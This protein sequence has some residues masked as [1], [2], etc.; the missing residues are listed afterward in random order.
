MKPLH[1]L[2]LS[3]IAGI[4]LPMAA[5]ASTVTW[6][7]PTAIT[8]ASDI[9]TTGLTD[10]AGANFG[11]TTGTTTL[12]TAA[13][14]GGSVDVE[15]K[16]L[17]SGQNATLSNNINVAAASAWGN[18]GN[19]AGNSA[20]TGN[21]GI[22]L[23][24]NIGIEP[25]V[26]TAN[27]TLS[28][29][30]IGTQY[31][32]QFF[33]DSTGNN[34]QAVSG[35]AG[36]NSIAGRFVTGTFTADATS[37]VLTVSYTTGDFAVVNALTIGVAGSVADTT[38]PEW[39]ATWPQ[40]DPLS[41]TS[42]TVRANA[43]EAGTAYYVVLP[44]GATPPSAAQ[45]KA[46]QDSSNTSV[47]TAGSLV[48]TASTEATTTVGSLS[49]G[50][51]YDV[52]FVAEDTVT[53]LQAASVKVDAS[54]LA[55]DVTA[56]TWTAT[57]P[58][59]TQ[60]TPTSITVR[61]QTNETGTAYYV[62]LADGATAPS[63]AQVQA[64]TDNT[65]T[66]AIAFGNFAL[67]A[68]TEATA[69]VTGL[70]ADTAYDVYLVAEDAVSNLQ[71]SPV[72]VDV[73]LV[74]PAFAWGTWTAVSDETAIQTPGGYTYGG[75]NFNGSDTTIG[76]VAFTGIAQNDSGVANGVTVTT[77][78]FAFQST[79]TGNSNVASAV[80]SPQT[81]ATVLDR[82]IGDDDD[83]ATIDL[84]GLTPGTD[85]T[86]QFFSST[87]DGG[88]NSTTKIT[89]VG[90][91]SPQFG[92]HGGGDTRYIVATFTANS[93]SQSFTINGAEPTF[94]AM[95]IGVE[96]TGNTFANWIGGYD[97]G[98]QTAFGDDAD[99]DGLDNGLENFL[100]T[101]PD[102][103]NAGLTAGTL[104][105][106][107]FTFTHPQNATPADDVSAP[108]Y[109]WSTDLVNWNAAGASAGGITVDL[110]AFTNTPSAGTTTVNATV[111]G[112][113]PPKLFVRLGVSQL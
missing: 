3:G 44:D 69:P 90:V 11:I 12:V 74:T 59:A 56:P 87:P 22:V 94:S 71:A 23:D 68:N 55:P 28:G 21:F 48:L 81:W 66:P 25:A 13:E 39:T 40:A 95:V 113:V 107:T 26:T 112:T 57:W 9:V 52:Y 16:S 53:N 60:L 47:S 61:A 7:T 73:A 31:Q 36:M 62:V 6:G 88:I 89:S 15:F 4:F 91:E 103:G 43:N 29:L 14:I 27:I 65:D 18:W 76:S 99:S 85:Y 108:V 77:S 101:A 104:S 111:T 63:A 82:V 37:Q 58:Q 46:G 32:I 97:V 54:T 109:T 92:A 105:G 78:G 96:S 79:G 1:K 75:V 106:D 45:V 100:G 10:V 80:G 83:A 34:T 67:T 93:T 38:P 102:A 17:R 41:S 19:A 20:V 33:A 8:G 50:T 2:L 30:T 24:S 35:S 5:S 64:G 98:S 72:L 42:I 70:T 84:T 86:V 51:A 49:P 110:T